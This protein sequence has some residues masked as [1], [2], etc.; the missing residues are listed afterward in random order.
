MVWPM[1]ALT[2]GSSLLGGIM[3]DKQANKQTK[4][5]NKAALKQNALNYLETQKAVLALDAQRAAVRQQATKS[6]T[7]ARRQANQEAGTAT[8]SAA[9]AGI[10]GMTANQVLGDITRDANEREYEIRNQTRLQ[11]EDID[12]QAKQYYSQHFAGLQTM[13]RSNTPGMGAHLLNGAMAA[14]NQ[15]AQAYYSFGAPATRR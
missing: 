8:A 9:A 11:L 3:Q 4:A 10:E 14:A 6:I 2:V 7:L 5:N 13:Q 1:L 12:V 15:Y